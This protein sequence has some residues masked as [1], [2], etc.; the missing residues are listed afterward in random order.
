MIEPSVDVEVPYA[1]HTEER[2]GAAVAQALTPMRKG[3]TA[4]IDS[5]ICQ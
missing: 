1:L 4:S 2:A 5:L 3:R